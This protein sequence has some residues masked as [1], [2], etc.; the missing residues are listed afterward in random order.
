[1]SA[2]DH[3]SGPQFGKHISFD[4]WHGRAFKIAT[5][6][7]GRATDSVTG[8]TLPDDPTRWSIVTPENGDAMTAWKDAPKAQKIEA[9]RSWNSIQ[10]DPNAQYKMDQIRRSI[11][12]QAKKK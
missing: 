11:V 1:M 9:K 4:R 3:L 6:P 12:K 2:Q 8:E 7:S 10:A 5:T